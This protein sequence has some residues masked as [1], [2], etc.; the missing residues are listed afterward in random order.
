[1]QRMIASYHDKNIDLLSWFLHYQ[2]LANVC[3]QFSTDTKVYP[4]TEADKE[5]SE[6]NREVVGGPS[7][8]FTQKAVVEEIFSRKSTNIF[9]ASVGIDASQIYPYSLCQPMSTGLYT[10]WYLNSEFDRFTFGQNKTH[11]F[12]NMV[13][14]FSQRTRLNFKTESFCTT[15]RQKK[16]DRFSLDGFFS[17]QH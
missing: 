5:L 4:F 7:I 10:L 6:K 12:E 15:G 1:M 13:T 11:S 14:S 16:T 3:L 8:V 17:L 2:N 9:K